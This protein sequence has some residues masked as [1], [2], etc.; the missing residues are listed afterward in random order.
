MFV[1][2]ITGFGGEKGIVSVMHHGEKKF[3]LWSALREE[4]NRG[5]QGR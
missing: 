2:V 5:K 1:G 4:V 3:F